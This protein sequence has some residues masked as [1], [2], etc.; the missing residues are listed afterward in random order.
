[1]AAKVTLREIAREVGL[2]TSAVSLVLNDRP[3]RISEENRRRIKEVAARMRYVPNQIARSLVMQQSN[4][5]GLIVPNIES[6]FFSSLA[7]NLELRF[8]EHGYALFI[9]NSDVSAEH[10][11]ELVRLL[12]NRGVDG[13][14]LVTAHELDADDRLIESLSTLTVP[15][16]MV[17]RVIEGVAC[18]RVR[19]GSETG[20]YLATKCLLEQGHTRIAC[21]VNTSSHTGRARLDGYRRALAEFSVEP[22]ERLVF[23][24]DYYIADGASATERVLETDATAIFASS[25]NIALGALKCLYAHDKRVP[26]DYS[27]VSYDNSAADALFEPALTA[28]EQNVGELADNAMELLLARIEC[29]PVPA[30]VSRGGEEA[31]ELTPEAAPAPAGTP[32][33]DRVLLP[34]LVRQASVAPYR[35]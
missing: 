34:K 26:R 1:M 14:I 16:V 27:M 24:T 11:D 5:I 17:D 33:E 35:H 18:D 28:I 15:L 8:R 30:D 20:G 4:T 7:R 29:G 10:E 25:D 19:F 23:E 31:D 12:V 2:S 3:C 22:D 13:L 32:F 21:L 6:R 9:M